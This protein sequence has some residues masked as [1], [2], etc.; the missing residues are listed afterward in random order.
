MNLTSE[1][2]V[3]NRNSNRNRCF[4][5]NYMNSNRRCTN[6]SFNL[7]FTRSIS[8]NNKNYTSTGTNWSTRIANA[9]TST[10]PRTRRAGGSGKH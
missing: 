4:D 8:N 5:T 7:G 2:D 6:K 9:T 3:S 10:T 1:R